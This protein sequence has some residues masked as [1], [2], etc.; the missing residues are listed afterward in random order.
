MELSIKSDEVLLAIPTKE[1][2]R[3]EGKLDISCGEIPGGSVETVD[4]VFV[5][6]GVKV[7][8]APEGV[9]HH[10]QYS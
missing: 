8:G 5:K 3:L 7:V 10:G 9:G 1:L 2:L 4:G 6:C